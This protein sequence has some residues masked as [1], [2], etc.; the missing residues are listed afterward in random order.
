MTTGGEEEFGY[1]RRGEEG[2]EL[3]AMIR[4]YREERRTGEVRAGGLGRGKRFRRRGEEASGGQPMGGLARGE[5]LRREREAWKGRGGERRAG[6]ET[7]AS[8][9]KRR[10]KDW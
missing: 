7:R 2:W 9:D 6:E 10:G 5:G 3:E 8:E 4:R 1:G